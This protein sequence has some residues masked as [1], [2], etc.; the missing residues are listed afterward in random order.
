MSDETIK[1]T[2]DTTSVPQ[3]YTAFRNGFLFGAGTAVVAGIIGISIGALVSRVSMEDI[4]PKWMRVAPVS[5]T[6][7]DA[8]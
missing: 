8:K 4:L 7:E 2:I 3:M 5:S 6:V 1:S